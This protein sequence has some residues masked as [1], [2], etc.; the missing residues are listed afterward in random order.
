MSLITDLEARINHLDSLHAETAKEV[1]TIA[2]LKQ[3]ISE[4]QRKTAETVTKEEITR[5]SAKQKQAADDMKSVGMEIKMLKDQLADMNEIKRKITQ[6]QKLPSEG[7]FNKLRQ[8]IDIIENAQGQFK[9]KFE[10]HGKK[11]N[12]LMDKMMG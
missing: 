6:L 12:I 10:D 2:T 8:R 3:Y 4:L 5:V 9:K 7:E 11:I 1:A